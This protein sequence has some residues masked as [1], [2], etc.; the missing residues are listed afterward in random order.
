MGKIELLAKIYLQQAIT[1]TY[2][3]NCEAIFEILKKIFALIHK[4]VD[5]GHAAII[6]MLLV[7]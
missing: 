2:L 4:N 7:N 6:I 1:G 5:T 3:Y